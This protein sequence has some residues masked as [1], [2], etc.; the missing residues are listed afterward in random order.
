KLKNAW[1]IW[2]TE[3]EPV[4]VVLKFETAVAKR[5]AETQWHHTQQIEVLEDGRLRWQA[6]VDE[7]REMLPWIRGWGADVEVLEPQELRGQVIRHV[8]EM[9]KQYG[10]QTENDQMDKPTELPE[11]NSTDSKIEQ[12]KYTVENEGPKTADEVSPELMELFDKFMDVG[13]ESG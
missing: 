4:E 13:E 12:T 10:L 2:Y 3:K 7:W 6:D 9:I 8:R 5:V 11:S 1:G